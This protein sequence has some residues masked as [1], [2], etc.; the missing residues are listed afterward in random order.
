MSERDLAGMAH[1]YKKTDTL[2]VRWNGLNGPVLKAGGSTKFGTH[3]G[4][5]LKEL[6]SVL[7]QKSQLKS[8]LVTIPEISVS[9]PPASSRRTFQP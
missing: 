2:L 3:H 7:P 6:S 4:I 1:D 5:D 8:G 9:C